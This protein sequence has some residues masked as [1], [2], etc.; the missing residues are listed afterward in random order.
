MMEFPFFLGLFFF[1]FFFFF[2]ANEKRRLVLGKFLS[3]GGPNQTKR[4]DSLVVKSG[5]IL[6]NRISKNFVPPNVCLMT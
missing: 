4:F 1:F 6:R 2:V 5:R 3:D